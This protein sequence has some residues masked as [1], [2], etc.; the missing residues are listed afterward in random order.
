M[1]K[2]D[3]RRSFLKRVLSAGAALSGAVTARGVAGATQATGVASLD[4][5]AIPIERVDAMV[6]F[7]RELGFTVRESPQVVSIHFGD[8]KINFHTPARWQNPDFT[9]RA[10]SALPPCGD[11]CWVWRGS[12]ASLLEA[13]ARADAKIVAE[14]E[15]SGGRDG[16]AAVGQSIYIRDPDG[17]LLEFMRYD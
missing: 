7:Y 9:L 14:G 15:R 3:P 12:R 11:F 10:P 16:G 6:S 5:V 4:H 8:Q 1:D 2:P 13:L 17:N